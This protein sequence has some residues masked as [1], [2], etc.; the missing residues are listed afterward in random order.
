M[1]VIVGGRQS[2]KTKA[3]LDWM[4]Q[5]PEDEVRV[6][7]SH[8]LQASMDLLRR[9]RQEDRKLESW[10]FISLEEV[11]GYSPIPVLIGRVKP[12]LGYDDLDLQIQGY[13]P[14]GLVT[15][16]GEVDEGL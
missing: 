11:K 14:I 3:M 5:A 8:T 1:R 2:G 16:T 9:A 10:Q 7:V 6:C 12:V 4:E 13:Y 15:L